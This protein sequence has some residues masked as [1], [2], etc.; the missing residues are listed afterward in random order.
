MTDRTAHGPISR[1]TLAGLTAAGLS[2]PVLA[3]CGDD[4]TGTD[5]PRSSG[6]AGPIST[7]DI[8]VSGGTIFADDGVVVTQ[9]SEGEFKAFDATCTHQGCTVSSV[10]GGTI[11]C[12][13]HGSKFSIEDGAVENGPATS[14]L[15][16]LAI[17]VE[18]DQIQLA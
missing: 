12:A 5:S 16:E 14:P 9:P 1:R 3:A 6:G 17:T 2:V 13:C 10:S 18:G 7:T 4:A 15:K 8:E 11:N